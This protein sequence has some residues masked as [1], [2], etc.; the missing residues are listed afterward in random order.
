MQGNITLTLRKALEVQATQLNFYCTDKPYADEIRAK[1]ASQTNVE[2]LDL[3]LELSA[4]IVNRYVPRGGAIEG[5]V[6]AAKDAQRQRDQGSLKLEHAYSRPIPESIDDLPDDLTLWTE[7]RLQPIGTRITSLVFRSKD[8][9]SRYYGKN[10]VCTATSV[11]RTDHNTV[12]S[13]EPWDDFAAAL[14]NA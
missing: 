12:E 3:D 2:G 9:K 4:H 11:H 5:L 13:I 7:D 6:Y 10:W 8:P 14:L 1:I